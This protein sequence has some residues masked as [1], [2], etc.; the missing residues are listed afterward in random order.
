MILLAYTFSADKM[1]I[2]NT[3]QGRA[4]ELVGSVEVEDR[5]TKITAQWGIYYERSRLSVLS[6]DA[7]VRGPDYTIRGDTVRYSPKTLLVQGN[8][9]LE[10]RYRTIK[11]RK[12][13]S[14]RD[15]A[16]AT[17]GVEIFL[18]K[19]KITLFGDSGVYDLKEKSGQLVGEA[20]ALI[21]RAE[22]VRVEAALFRM[23]KD[24]LWAEGGVVARS[25][26]WEA[27]GRRMAGVSE[28]GDTERITLAD[29]C[30]VEWAEGWGEADTVRV[31]LVNGRVRRLQLVGSAKATR[32]EGSARLTLKADAI[33]LVMD[34]EGKL[35]W[36]ESRGVKEGVYS[37]GP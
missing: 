28:E 14:V 3:P 25:A 33:T 24:T 1:V 36:L 11:A 10:D 22:T 20:R 21:A 23:V 35:A 37:E 19:K 7:L 27:R 6:G 2:L 9:F 12:V 16:W 17:G 13:L 4:Y 8:A 26:S 29:T 18:K 32:R 30:R 31:L 34:E 15:S 5:G